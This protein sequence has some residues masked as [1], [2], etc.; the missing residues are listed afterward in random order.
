MHEKPFN[1]PI[2]EQLS[3]AKIY[4]NYIVMQTPTTLTNHIGYNQ[5]STV[6]AAVAIA[7]T[8]TTTRTTLVILTGIAPIPCLKLPLLMEVAE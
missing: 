5:T 4:Y 2:F 8:R 7:A 6:R 3:L 1:S